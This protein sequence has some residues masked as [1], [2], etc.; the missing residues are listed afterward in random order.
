MANVWP[1]EARWTLTIIK[2]EYLSKERANGWQ[3][4]ERASLL[5]WP[6]WAVLRC[7]GPAKDH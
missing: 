1:Q 3:I 2:Y 4:G 5:D 7:F 6:F